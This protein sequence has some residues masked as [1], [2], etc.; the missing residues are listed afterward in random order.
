[1]YFYELHESDEDLF[2]DALLVHELEFDEDEFLELVLEARARVLGTFE[3]DTLVEAVAREL[4]RTRGF[5][6]VGDERL[7]ASVRLSPEEG[8][9]APTPVEEARVDGSEPEGIRFGVQDD[10]DYRSLLVERDPDDERQ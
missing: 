2:D 9:T 8:Q 3:E 1:V 7:R 5:V 6:Y 10:A 4:E